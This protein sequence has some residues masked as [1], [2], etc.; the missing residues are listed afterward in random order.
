[1]DQQFI[2]ECMD[3]NPKTGVCTWRKR[4]RHHFE[5]DSKYRS[6]NSRCAGQKMGTPNKAGGYL[7]VRINKRL[8]RLHRLIYLW[9][10]GDL[11]Y[12][13]DHMNRNTQD[14][15]WNNLR[16]ATHSQN[17]ANNGRRR[18][19]PYRGITLRRSKYVAQC[20]YK[21]RPQ[22]LGSFNN[23]EDAARAYDQRAKQLFGEFAVLNFPE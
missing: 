15:R 22:Y 1:M 20:S 21:G 10:T 4:P 5:T 12:F 19:L 18:T 16:A 17:Q 9:M 7:V 8:Y 11:P 2:R 13:V 6:I 23:M 14:N 3:Y